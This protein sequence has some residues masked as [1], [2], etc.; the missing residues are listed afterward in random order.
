[1][2]GHFVEGIIAPEFAPAAIERL[3]KRE[4]IRLMRPRGSWT[5]RPA[6]HAIHVRGGFLVQTTDAP[7][8]TAGELK[9]ATKAKP[10][11][12]QIRDLLFATTV[13]KHAKSNAVVLANDRATL[14]IGAGQ[15]SRVD[16][17]RLAAMKAEGR[18]RGSVLS[19]DAFFPFRD[20]ID[21]A[22]RA[23]VA[24][25]LQPGGSIRDG[26]VVDAANEHG[27]PMVFSG[28][29]FFKH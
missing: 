29:R 10:T 2:K 21:E 17:V 24:A 27:I 13:C 23:G 3:R 25:I 7:K 9:V 16:A 11:A 6:W 28:V 12:A 20:G 5:S 19:S 22:A 1:M 14:A 18:A 15:V 26:E 4:N 8:L